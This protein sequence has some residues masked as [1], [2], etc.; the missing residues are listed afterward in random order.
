MS[1]RRSRWGLLG[2]V[3]L[4]AGLGVALLFWPYGTLCGTALFGYLASVGVLGATGVVAAVTSWRRRAP[5]AHVISLTVV[6]WAVVLAAAQVLPRTAYV[7]TDPA[8]R[9]TWFCP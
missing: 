9:A 8:A 6:L 5:V 4:A 1:D 2:R 3:A 7:A